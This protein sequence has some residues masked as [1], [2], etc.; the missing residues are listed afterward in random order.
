MTNLIGING[1][2]GAGKDTVAKIIQYILDQPNMPT[3][4]SW[5]L[6]HDEKR[7]AKCSGWEIRKFAYKLKQICFILTG[8]PVEDFEKQE[9]KDRFLGPE[10]SEGENPV[11]SGNF[12]QTPSVKLELAS[13]YKSPTVRK[14]LQTVGTEAMR[15]VIHENVWVN[16][17]F[18]DWKA[19]GVDKD[20]FYVANVPEIG[21]I[22]SKPNPFIDSKV[23]PK[24]IISDMRFENEM[25]AIKDHG[26]I[27]IRVTRPGWIN[28]RDMHPSETSLD[29]A[30]FDFELNN[31]GSIDDLIVKVREVL[32]KAKIIY[33]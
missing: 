23:F 14:L 5:I 7:A 30:T 16:A 11:Y 28:T 9:V 25:K 4:D 24:W 27:T 21:I 12:G 19:N 20:G 32:L 10:W 31:D 33:T 29:N 18:A 2:I 22:K 8:I 13:S 6:A 17:L 15:N 1:K 26:G 3:F